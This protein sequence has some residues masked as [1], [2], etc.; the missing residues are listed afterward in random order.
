VRCPPQLLAEARAASRRLGGPSDLE[1]FV[2]DLL[3]RLGV[4]DHLRFVLVGSQ[5]SWS[6]SAWHSEECAVSLSLAPCGRLFP[7][8]EGP[9]LSALRGIAFL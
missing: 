4:G 9:D 3:E 6:S 7:A 2:E 8:P 5:P 1:Q